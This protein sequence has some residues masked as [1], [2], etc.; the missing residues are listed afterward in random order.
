M[1]GRV[2]VFRRITAP[3]VPAYQ[4]KPQVD[5]SVPQ[6][7]TLFANVRLCGPDFYLIQVLTGHFFW[8]RFRRTVAATQ[9]AV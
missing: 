7:H 1:L 9:A 3:H 6:L 4:A 2:L 8:P 5:P